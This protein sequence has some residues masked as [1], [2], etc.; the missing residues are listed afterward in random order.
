M[1]V[2]FPGASDIAKALENDSKLGGQ[3]KTGQFKDQ[4][5][6]QKLANAFASKDKSLT[7]RAQQHAVGT[8]M[9]DANAMPGKLDSNLNAIQ[10]FSAAL[11]RIPAVK[12]R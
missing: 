4:A 3:F 10:E 8:V 6:I 11:S 7:P 5:F 1:A 2:R 12:G 9:R